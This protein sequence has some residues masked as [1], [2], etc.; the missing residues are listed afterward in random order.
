[1]GQCNLDALWDLEDGNLFNGLVSIFS[2]S[3]SLAFFFFSLSFYFYFN[4]CKFC[5]RM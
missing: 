4:L 1:M 5:V 3:L 2:L